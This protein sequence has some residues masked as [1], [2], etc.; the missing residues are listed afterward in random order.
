MA[1]TADPNKAAEVNS[2]RRTS[3]KSRPRSREVR[4]ALN[5]KGTVNVT[6]LINPMIQLD[7]CPS[8]DQ[9]IEPRQQTIAAAEKTIKRK[10]QSHAIKAGVGSW[11]MAEGDIAAP[12]HISPSATK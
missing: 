4:A 8:T 3:V 7:G 1:V 10:F 5:I 9:M 11:I 6:A 12:R 2:P